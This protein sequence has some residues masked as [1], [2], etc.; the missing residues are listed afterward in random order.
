VD[1]NSMTE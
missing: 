1:I